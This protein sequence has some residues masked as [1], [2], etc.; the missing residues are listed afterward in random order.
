V[1]SRD[2]KEDTTL[3]GEKRPC[4]IAEILMAI[5]FRNWNLF[6]ICGFTIR[7]NQKLG[8]L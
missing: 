7:G 1:E 3:P 8:S 2:K 6:N 4:T 5:A